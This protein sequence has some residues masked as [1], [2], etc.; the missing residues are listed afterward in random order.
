[1]A[2][3]ADV[4]IAGLIVAACEPG[5]GMVDQEVQAPIKAPKI[6]ATLRDRP[7]AAA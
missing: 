2:P 4:P 1:M 3:L 7:T 6:G 5:L